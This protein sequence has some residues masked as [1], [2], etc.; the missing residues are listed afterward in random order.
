MEEWRDIK[1]YEG[2]YQVSNLG[3]VKSFYRNTETIK[4]LSDWKGGLYLVVSLYKDKIHKTFN[5]HQL[6]AEAFLNH[7]PCRYK[8]VI[9]H[10]DN[11]PLNNNVENI[12]LITPRQNNS[13]DRLGTSKYVGVC[14][15]KA[16]G[17]WKSGIKTKGVATHLGYFHCELKAHLEYVKALAELK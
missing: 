14:W 12:Q 13:K 1:G 4:K 10:I 2:Y 5:V 11:N 6:V 3:R 7:K 15:D 16:R 8:L 9:D 17:K